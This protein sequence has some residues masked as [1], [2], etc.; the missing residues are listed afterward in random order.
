MLEDRKKNV[1]IDLALLCLNCQGLDTFETL[2][3]IT[4]ILSLGGC[5]FHKITL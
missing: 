4:I 2:Y 1:V 5:H 3:I